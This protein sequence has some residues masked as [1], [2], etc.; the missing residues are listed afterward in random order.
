MG[1]DPIGQVEVRF[2]GVDGFFAQATLRP[3]AG[4]GHF[5]PVEFPGV[6]A[7]EVLAFLS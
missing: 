6:I 5:A 1:R 4:A 3:V 2:V 7:E